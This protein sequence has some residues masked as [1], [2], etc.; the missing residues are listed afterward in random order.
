M[1]RTE[2]LLRLVPVFILFG[3]IACADNDHHDEYDY[4]KPMG[5]DT[6]LCRD[7]L[8]INDSVHV[9]YSYPGGC[10]GLESLTY[11]INTDTVVVSLVWNYYYH[12]VPC[13][14][15][16]GVDTTALNLDF[17]SPGLYTIAYVKPDSTP[18][19]LQTVVP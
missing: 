10:N 18:V 9:V 4:D 6:I 17:P 19:K 1:R 8:N 7:T 11:L 15:G 2:P 13:A 3:T 16:S 14:H 12:G 5:I